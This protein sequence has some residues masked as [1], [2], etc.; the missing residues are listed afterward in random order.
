MNKTGS[1]HINAHV[2]NILTRSDEKHKISW[3]EL[4][5]FHQCAKLGLIAGYPGQG[6]IQSS[7]NIIDKAA[8]IEFFRTLGPPLVRFV[9]LA[10]GQSC[11]FN[12]QLKVLNRVLGGLWS[13][14]YFHFAMGFR[15]GHFS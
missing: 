7:K 3:L 1:T 10:S 8:A 13:S 4:T 6:Y 9:Q 14:G 11:R 5:F 15:K 2:I 12:S